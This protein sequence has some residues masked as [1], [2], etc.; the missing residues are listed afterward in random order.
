MDLWTDCFDEGDTCPNCKNT[1][2]LRIETI[3]PSTDYGEPW[4]MKLE[5][6]KVRVCRYCGIEVGL[7]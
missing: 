6:Y 7:Y 4:G 2:C 5:P 3:Y 1:N